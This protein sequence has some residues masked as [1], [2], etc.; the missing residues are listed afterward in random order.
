MLMDIL[1]KSGDAVARMSAGKA[2]EKAKQ[3]QQW[4]K[5][6]SRES[7]DKAYEA[8][9]P[10]AIAKLAELRSRN[11]KATPAEILEL[12]EDSLQATESSAGVH[13]TEFSSAATLYV[14]TAI[15]VYREAGATEVN[16]GRVTDIMLAIDSSVVRNTRK[17]IGVAIEFLPYLQSIKKLKFLKKVTKIGKTKAGIG[18][19][20]LLSKTQIAGGASSLISSSVLKELGPVP[21]SWPVDRTVKGFFKRL[22]SRRAK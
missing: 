19:A 9:R 17:A 11:P 7:L 18:V 13:S 1:Y 3:A 6:K 2:A 21:E 14:L 20:K 10:T 5:D 8:R 15:E 22:F 16:A 4:V 12:L